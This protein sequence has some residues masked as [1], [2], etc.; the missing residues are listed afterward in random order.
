MSVGTLEE[1]IDDNHAIVSTRSLHHPSICL[2]FY[3]SICLSVYPSIYLSVYPSIYLSIYPLS[4]NL[5]A[6]PQFHSFLLLYF[7]SWQTSW[8]F[9]LFIHLYLVSI[10]ISIFIQL[11]LSIFPPIYFWLL[12]SFKLFHLSC[13]FFLFPAILLDIIFTMFFFSFFSFLSIIYFIFLFN[14]I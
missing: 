6:I 3:L 4:R 9:Y 13:S 11:F 5:F 12:T 2:S 10:Y 8:Y 7:F 1:I 14:I